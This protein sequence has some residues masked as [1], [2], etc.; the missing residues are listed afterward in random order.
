MPDL[1]LVLFGQGDEFLALARLGAQFGARIDAFSP[2]ERD[3][4]ALEA[5]GITATHLAS[6]TR[7]PVVQGDPWSAV[8][9]LFHERD[10]EDALLPD[11]LALPA[12]YHG[13][14]GSARTHAG[15]LER[16]AAQGVSPDLIARLQ[17]R[18]G[19]IPSTRDPASLALSILAQIVQAHAALP[20]RMHE[21][22]TA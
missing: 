17:G 12:F 3:I 7:R 18:I 5:L 14:V 4:P 1:R 2:L 13:A 15:R 10:W 6:T 8:A 11:A 19:L 21:E 20:V 16:L 9:F 22:A